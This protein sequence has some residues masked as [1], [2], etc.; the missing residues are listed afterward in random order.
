MSLEASSD[1]DG[2]LHAVYPLRL[3][4]KQ[5]RQRWKTAS[6]KLKNSSDVSAAPQ[7]ILLTHLLLFSIRA[8]L[9]QLCACAHV[10][11]CVRVC[12]Y[13]QVLVLGHDGDLVA[14]HAEDLSLQVDQLALTHL[15][16][17][18]GLQVVLTLLT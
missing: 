5:Q 2:R 18:A 13:L 1:K 11:A 8:G 12:A 4:L 9:L 16:V 14:V 15:H 6:W 3:Y 10:C 17:V 7:Q